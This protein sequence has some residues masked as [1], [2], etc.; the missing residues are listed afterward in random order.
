MFFSKN[1]NNN[2][3]LSLTKAKFFKYFGQKKYNQ[4]ISDELSRYNIFFNSE[5]NLTLEQTFL[6]EF[7]VQA[8]VKLLEKYI[9]EK[10]SI[11]YDLDTREFAN[12]YLKRYSLLF[13]SE[14]KDMKIENNDLLNKKLKDTLFAKLRTIIYQTPES[15]SLLITYKLVK[16]IE[17]SKSGEFIFTDIYENFF[18]E[19]NLISR[20]TSNAQKLPGNYYMDKIELLKDINQTLI[21]LYNKKTQNYFQFIISTENDDKRPSPIVEELKFAA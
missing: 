17:V 16:L 7:G 8:L 4:T 9:F 13:I 14:P 12:H 18:Y 5:N 11:S 1:N 20:N 6:K 2:G 3:N 10:V 19:Q 15:K 21:E